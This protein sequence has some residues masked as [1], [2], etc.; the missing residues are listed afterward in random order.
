MKLKLKN[1]RLSFPNL[2]T[3]KA[4]DQPGSVPKFSAGLLLEPTDKQVKEIEAAMVEVAKQKWGAK[5]EGIYKSMKATDKLALHNGDTKAQYAGY[6]GMVFVNAS[7]PA[8]PLVLD[9]DKTPLGP[10]DGKPYGGCYV[11]ASIEL[12]AQDNKFGKRIN[13]GLGGVQ[14]FRDGDRFGGGTTADETDFDELEDGADADD[15]I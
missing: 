10:E 4:G 5:W 6:E 13:A 7:N 9:R 11:N 12:W 2:F 1:V 15:D 8:R 14:F 3:A